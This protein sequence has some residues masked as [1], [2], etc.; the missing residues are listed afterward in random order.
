M[1]KKM[2]VTIVNFSLQGNKENH[3]FVRFNTVKKKKNY[4]WSMAGVLENDQ[5]RDVKKERASN[6]MTTVK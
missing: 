5:D 6:N 4:P 2:P 1:K 3:P